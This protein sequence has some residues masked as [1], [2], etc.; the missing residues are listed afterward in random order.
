MALT[1]DQE[2]AAFAWRCLGGL[3]GD[4]KKYTTAVQTFAGTLRRGG[5]AVAVA[6]LDRLE[7]RELKQHLC[8]ARIA[9][10]PPRAE[11]LAATVFAMDAAAYMIA[12]REAIAVAV[13]LKRAAEARELGGAG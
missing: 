2:R 11:Q 10:F 4:R 9:G 5:L 3:T 13:W 7:A 1:R 6:T 8:E 12:T